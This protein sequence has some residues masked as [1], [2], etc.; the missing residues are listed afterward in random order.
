[1]ERQAEQRAVAWQQQAV[2]EQPEQQ[3]RLQDVTQERAEEEQAE[4]LADSQEP[5][6]PFPFLLRVQR[7]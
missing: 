2:V 1:M 7:T 3:L 5:I 6:Q 4:E